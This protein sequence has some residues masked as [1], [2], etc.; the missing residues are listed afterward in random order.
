MGGDNFSLFGSYTGVTGRQKAVGAGFF[1]Y[2][3]SFST[4]HRS[5]GPARSRWAPPRHAKRVVA[6]SLER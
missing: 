4:H 2:S 3:T 5:A 6:R 1:P